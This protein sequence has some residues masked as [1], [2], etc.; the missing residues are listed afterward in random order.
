MTMTKTSEN[1][2]Y[3]KV[4]VGVVVF[5]DE[6]VLLIKRGKPPRAGEWSLPGGKQELGETLQE[7][8]HREVKEETGISI[9]ITG[10]VDVVDFIDRGEDDIRFHYSLIDFAAQ[11]QGGTLAPASD[12]VEA[13]FFT[14]E[15]ALALP[16]WTETKRILKKAAFMQA[17]KE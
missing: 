12:A 2:R 17:R 10:L 1:K 16:L 6:K 13:K 14:L 3:P 8:A 4:G 15:D 7:A 9:T 5:Q 11:Y